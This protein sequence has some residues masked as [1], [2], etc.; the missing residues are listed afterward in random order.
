MAVLGGYATAA[1]P[2]ILR[3]GKGGG[4]TLS[5][6]IAELRG[7]RFV[8]TTETSGSE[9]MD[10]PKTK[11]LSGG[12]R[13]RAR[14][15][16][17]SSSEFDVQ[18]LLWYGTNFVPRLSGED[19][20]LWSRFAPVMFP[21][22]WTESGMGPDGKKCET[23]DPNLKKRLI[24]EAPGILA[25]I[26]RHLEKLYAEGLAEPKA[27]TAKREELQGQ[28]DTSG[29]F[30]EMAKAASN[31]ASGI[32]AVSPRDPLLAAGSRMR[33]RWTSLY[34]HYEALGGLLQDQRGR[35]GRVPGGAGEPRPQVRQA[36]QRRVGHRLRPPGQQGDG[37]VPRLR[38]D[39]PRAEEDEE[40]RPVMNSLS[41]ISVSVA[42]SCLVVWQMPGQSGQNPP[43]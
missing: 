43:S 17:Q 3:K 34:R 13:V 35:Q 11:R 28:Q 2:S 20:A 41:V 1:A 12:D 7:F 30:I 18:F 6:D 14:G 8:S 29:Q 10:E 36:V 15:L 31:P 21:H 27:V 24:A 37:P 42:A 39:A 4:G 9:E 40:A 38:G 33:I 23:A 26:I 5:D 32:T 25:W 16:Y 19:L 22:M